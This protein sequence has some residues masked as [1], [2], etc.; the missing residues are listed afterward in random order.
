MAA[1]SETRAVSRHRDVTLI[2]VG[3]PP[4]CEPFDPPVERRR[5]VTALGESVD[6][7]RSLAGGDE[8]ATRILVLEQGGTSRSSSSVIASFVC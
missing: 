3:E 4:V 1:T 2:L 6:G 8:G 7:Q 5:G